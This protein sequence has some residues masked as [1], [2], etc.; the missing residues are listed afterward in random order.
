ML[1]LLAVGQTANYAALVAQLYINGEHKGIQ[2]FIV[3][4]RDEETHMPLPGID[5]GEV[6]KRVGMMAV[7]QGYLG[8]TKVRIPRT[9]M[10]MKHAKVMPNGDFVQSPSSK[11]TYMT[12]VYTRCMIVGL[13][14]MYLLEAATIATRYAAVRRQSPINAK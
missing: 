10:L 5:V 9:N 4:L 14:I 3:P 12:M 1:L 6:G 13:E 11:L 8:L 7:N 2:M